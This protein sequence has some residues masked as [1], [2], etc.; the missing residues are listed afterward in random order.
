MQ[1]VVIRYAQK[2]GTRH[3]LKLAR[4]A[5]A[6]MAKGERKG[7]QLHWPVKVCPLEAG[8]GMGNEIAPAT[9]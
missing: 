8:S 5:W 1:T 9:A 6:M 3:R 7:T 2:H 4:M